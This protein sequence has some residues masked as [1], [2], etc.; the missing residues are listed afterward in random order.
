[1]FIIWNDGGKWNVDD[2]LAFTI[3][4]TVF[5]GTTITVNNV[6][7]VYLMVSS[8]S[9]VIYYNITDNKWVFTTSSSPSSGLFTSTITINN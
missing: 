5:H 1:M 4:G 2:T 3:S 8:T 6:T 9:M 7:Y